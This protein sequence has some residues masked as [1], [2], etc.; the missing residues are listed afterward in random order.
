MCGLILLS[1]GRIEEAARPWSSF[2]ERVR[3]PDVVVSGELA[4]LLREL[5]DAVRD[6]DRS[7]DLE[8]GAHLLEL[9]RRLL[10]ATD[11][12]E[13]AGVPAVGAAALSR[14]LRD[15]GEA[16]RLGAGTGVSPEDWRPLAAC[17]R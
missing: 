16:A 12:A 17:C 14:V 13:D 1:A 15:R 8:L 11:G 10:L 2:A 9:H 5:A 4:H 3:D 6:P 7:A